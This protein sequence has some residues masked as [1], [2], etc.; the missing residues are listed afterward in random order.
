MSF[1][2]DPVTH[3]IVVTVPDVDGGFTVRLHESMSVQGITNHLK[4]IEAWLTN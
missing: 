3:D 4:E 2:Y 1:A